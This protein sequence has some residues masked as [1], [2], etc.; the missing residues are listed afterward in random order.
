MIGCGST[1]FRMTGLWCAVRSLR[2][3]TCL[4][5]RVIWKVHLPIDLFSTI[6]CRTRHLQDL[7]HWFL[8]FSIASTPPLQPLPG[9]SQSNSVPITTSATHSTQSEDRQDG[10]YSRCSIST[11]LCSLPDHH[12]AMCGPVLAWT[13]GTSHCAVYSSYP[14]ADCPY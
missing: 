1:C 11:G 10:L 14:W 3:T 4:P 8:I 5:P 6:V 12:S 9:T 13:H 7:A 2:P